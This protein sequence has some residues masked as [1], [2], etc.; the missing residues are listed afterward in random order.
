MQ[1]INDIAAFDFIRYANCWEDA[2]V[3]LEALSP[4]AGSRIFSIASAGD[5]SFSLLVTNPEI[6]VAADISKVQ[7]QLVQLKKIAYQYLSYEA[8]LGFL[9]FTDST[10]RIETFYTI[11]A[12]LDDDCKHYFENNI[13]LIEKGII[14]QGKFEKYLCFFAKKILPWIHNAKRIDKLMEVKSAEDQKLFY[15]SHWNSW[16]WRLLFKIFFSKYVMGK[17]GRDPQ[18]MKEVFSNVGETI[19]KQTADHF[20]TT[21]AQSNMILH[22]CL[23]GNF[24]NLL[25]HYVRPENYTTIKT[26]LHKLHIKQGYAEDIA[27]VYNNFDAMNLSNIFEYM[28]KETF[29]TVSAK[30]LSA[31]S[32]G[33]RLVYW[34]LMVQRKMSTNNADKIIA[35]EELSSTLKN[36]DTGFFYN[37]V[38]IDEKI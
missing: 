30:I 33:A 14:H 25:P 31:S 35:H 24:G 4:K 11:K 13:Q 12:F 8:L 28:S 29:D 16:R 21:T 3:L 19:F 1:Q 15:E 17:Y 34:N 2:D 38:N 10:K 37:C 6:V 27:L 36:I 32:K 9:G 26:N 18:F 5:N 20:K 7:L 22:Y 23:K